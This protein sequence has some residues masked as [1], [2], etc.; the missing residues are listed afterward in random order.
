MIRT[1]S[2]KKIVMS[3]LVISISVSAAE[4]R[5]LECSYNYGKAGRR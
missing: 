1:N 4:A 5:Q 3:L 2:L